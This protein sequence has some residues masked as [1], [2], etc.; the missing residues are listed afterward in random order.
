[1]SEHRVA[2]LVGEGDQQHTESPGRRTR[3]SRA[4]LAGSLHGHQSTEN[5]IL[6]VSFISKVVKHYIDQVLQNLL[7]KVKRQEGKIPHTAQLCL[8]CS[9][10]ADPRWVCRW[11]C[12]LLRW[13]NTTVDLKCS[14]FLCRWAWSEPAW[15]EEGG[16]GIPPKVF[17]FDQ[18]RIS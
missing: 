2:A 12:L 1:M 10:R 6:L 7:A 13:D 16:G 5:P 11:M 8:S 17:R 15:C 3:I 4:H 18:K 14:L 9:S